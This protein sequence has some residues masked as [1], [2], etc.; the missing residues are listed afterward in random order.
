MAISID[1][2]NTNIISIPQSYLSLIS[3]TI[4][5]LDTETFREDLKDLED[6]EAGMPFPDTHIHNT[7]VTVAGTI[8]ARTIEILSPYSVEFEDGQYTVILVGSNNNIFDVA[9]GILVQNQ[10]QV[11]ST[12]SAGLIVS[13]QGSG[14]TEQDKLDI[15]DRVWDETKSGHTTSDTFGDYLDTKVSTIGGGSITISGIAD[16]VWDEDIVSAHTIVDTAGHIVSD[17]RFIRR[18]IH[19]DT[20]AVSNGDGTA[21]N[22][23]DNIGDAIDT[24]EAHEI[25]EIV[26]YSEITV[27]RNLKNFTIIGIGSPIINCNGQDLK[28]SEFTRCT[29][30]G[31]YIDRITATE[32][33][34]DDGFELNGIF[35]TVALNGDLTCADNATVLL[36]NAVSNIAGL[37]RPT[38]S[39]NSGT[40]T[41]LSIRNYSG[42]LTILDSDHIN[43]VCTVEM[44]QGK[45]TID[46]T[47]TL[48]LISIRGIAQFTDNS[49]GATIDITGLMQPGILSSN[50]E[51][52]LGLTG[53]NVK[54]SSIT[55]NADNLMTA[56]RI[57]HYT[58]NTLVT[59]IKSWDVTATYNGSGEITTYQ[60]VEV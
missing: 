18:V 29:L 15:A 39:M 59:P 34:L 20:D 30:R 8:F 49:A 13:V 36:S 56:A 58:D 47:C 24:A 7:E 4:Y 42:G 43:D 52:I 26:V 48:G 10:V 2:G 22:P 5:Q 55:H 3:G 19:V 6:D 23:F 11:I 1:W 60:M 37:S 53:E 32:C 51:L 45:L 31:T 28:N 21:G 33:L 16:A 35:D 27:D 38:I 25:K 17:S 46:S 44:S 50:I 40:A 57:T 9:N 41:A 12:N 54:W 14:V